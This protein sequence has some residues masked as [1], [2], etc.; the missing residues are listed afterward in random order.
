MGSG[1]SAATFAGS[2]VAIINPTSR[3]ASAFLMFEN[4]R[5]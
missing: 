2:V 5:G 4:H 3:A 1:S